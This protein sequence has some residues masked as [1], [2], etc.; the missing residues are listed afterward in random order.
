VSAAGLVVGSTGCARH[1]AVRA[2]HHARMRARMKKPRDER[3]FWSD[4]SS[5][6]NQIMKQVTQQSQP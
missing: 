2:L 5:S 1:F 6:S 3:G 4:S